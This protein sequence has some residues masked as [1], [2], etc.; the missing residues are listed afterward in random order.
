VRTLRVSALVPA[1]GPVAGAYLPPQDRIRPGVEEHPNPGFHRALGT[2]LAAWAST[3]V[4]PG[5]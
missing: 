3:H 4:L 2:A 5:A 1:I